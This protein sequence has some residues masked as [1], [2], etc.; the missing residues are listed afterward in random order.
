M[1]TYRTISWASRLLVAA[2][3]SWRDS[4]NFQLLSVHTES[5]LPDKTV[6]RHWWERTAESWRWSPRTEI[7]LPSRW[8]PR[9][10]ALCWSLLARNPGYSPSS[11]GTKWRARPWVPGDRKKSSCHRTGSCWSRCSTLGRTRVRDHPGGWPRLRWLVKKNPR[12]ILLFLW[13]RP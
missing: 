8:S 4:S 1:W 10:P 13:K 3:I 12:H 11:N 9:R 6:V 5:S 2:C 7:C